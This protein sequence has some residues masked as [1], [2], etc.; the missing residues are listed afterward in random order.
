MAGSCLRARCRPSAPRATVPPMIGLLHR[1]L[2]LASSSRGL[3]WAGL[4]LM[5]VM[6]F[7]TVSPRLAAAACPRSAS[8]KKT[9]AL[10]GDNWQTA[11]HEAGGKRVLAAFAPPL[12]QDIAPETI[13][14]IDKGSA[15]K[16]LRWKLGDSDKGL[17]AI[18]TAAETWKMRLSRP[19]LDK[20]PPTERADETAWIRLDLVASWGGNLIVNQE[21][22]SFA[23]LRQGEL[24]H[25]FSGIGSSDENRYD[26]C[27][28]KSVASFTLV[29]AESATSPP[30][31]L[32]TTTVKL[33]KGPAPVEEPPAVQVEKE[34]VA[35]EQTTDRFPLPAP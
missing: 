8:I 22:V 20:R 9:L 26:I 31:L 29:P 13:V 15:T 5:S 27:L 25:V 4:A 10:A 23:R 11:C 32:R 18:T 19:K 30:T 14:A 2:P 24:T 7:V 17:R 6:G 35:P 12:G 1:P 34:C 28:V 3:L 33:K 16:P 21:I